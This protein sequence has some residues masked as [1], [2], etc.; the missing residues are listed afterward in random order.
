MQQYDIAAKVLLEACRNEIIR[1]FLKI[2][3]KDS[4]IITSLPQETVSLKRSDFPVLVTDNEGNT[5][6]IIIEI[7]TRWTRYVPLNLL[8]Y[9]TRY[10]LEHDMEAISCVLLLKPSST[11]VDCFEDNEV[12]FK[13]N[14]IKIYEMDSR[15]IIK[16][17]QV[18]LM[19]F[20]PLMQ[21]GKEMVDEAD[22]L[23][24]QSDVPRKNKADMLTSMAILSGIVSQD[25]PHQLIARRKDIMIESA[26]YDIIKQ[27]GVHE[28]IQQGIQQGI[29]QGIQQG[30]QQG[31][32]ESLMTILEIKFGIEGVGLYQKIE[33]IE[34]VSKIK[35][36]IQAA[37]LAE[38][39]EQL[40]VFIKS[41]D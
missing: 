12:R 11:A 41:Q 40:L 2:D 34:D 16:N 4:S 35:A 1:Y 33:K 22:L 5:R 18:C 15:E 28:G 27:E 39:S 7:Q 8:D 17:G 23:I 32:L 24:Y 38:S 14:L 19:P 13:F 20:V 9:R 21:Y 36:I 3:I 31:L 25:L 10:L 29:E 26:A 37:K 6:L 30:M